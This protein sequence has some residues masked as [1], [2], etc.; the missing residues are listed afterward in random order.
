MGLNSIF[1]TDN[2][3][4]AQGVGEVEQDFVMVF[5]IGLNLRILKIEKEA[6]GQYARD[7]KPTKC[8]EG[9]RLT[10]RRLDRATI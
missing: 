8:G 7:E 5:S 4:E 2:R 3:A 1:G 6:R 9:N 10:E